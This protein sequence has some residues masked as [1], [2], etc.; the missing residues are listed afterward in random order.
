MS[1]IVLSPIHVFSFFELS[2]IIITEYMSLKIMVQV[3]GC[4]LCL[5]FLPRHFVFLGY[6][7]RVEAID[8]VMVTY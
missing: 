8:I 2:F 3:E 6:A 5:Q 4:V 7:T 1:L